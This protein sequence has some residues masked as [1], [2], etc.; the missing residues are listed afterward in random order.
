ML[1]AEAD[2]ANA[3]VQTAT[4][5]ANSLPDA[6]AKAQA[7]LNAK[8]LGESSAS[9][10]I[11]KLLDEVEANRGL[12]L[13][14][15]TEYLEPKLPKFLYF[16]EYYQMDGQVNIEQL[17]QRKANGQLKNSDRPMLGLIELA[18]LD[19]DKLLNPE[20][21][22]TLINKL[23][24]ASNHLSRQVLKYWS[25]NKHLQVKFD[26]RAAN[27]GDPDGMTNGTNLWG[28]VH[29]SVHFV[30]TRLGTRSK[31]FVWFFSFLAW[32]SQQK[33]Q[34]ENLVLLLDEPGLF[35]HAKAQ[36]DLLRY[37]EEELKPHHQVIY[38]THSPFMVDSK[39]FDRVRIV[40]DRSMDAVDELDDAEKGTKVLT[41]VLEASVDS[42]FPIQGALGYDIAQTL[43][44]GPNSLI[45]EGVSDLLYL[46][47]MSAVLESQN[48]VG[49]NSQWTITPVGGADKVPAF[50]SLIG[51]QAGMTVAALIDYQKK[52]AQKIENLY[53]RKLLKKS[54]VLTYADFTGGAEADVE[55]M[56]DISFYLRLVNGEFKANLEKNVTKA[57]LGKDAARVVVK[58]ETLLSDGRLKNA[59]FNH[60]RPARYFSE[61]L[62]NLASK[63][64]EE[65]LARFEAAFVAL[66]A[67][68]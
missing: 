26:V 52:D 36:A 15:W 56:F 33:K 32:F 51:S 65:S 39:H 5:E 2:L 9:V 29:D 8:A 57:S 10:A 47:T 20:R 12:N 24:G 13:H 63:I 27:A 4:T 64:P 44:V 66:N 1:S 11:R 53:K 58:I 67:I 3:A 7:L 35:L 61:N 17:K 40:E 45:V 50:C 59:K 42:L 31:G 6:T 48:R 38:S 41:E 62:S 46:Q 54:N 25:Q 28:R 30:S 14:I 22:E 21:T 49:L 19:L 55:D 68:I 34:D 43:F 60:Y 37:I 16:D 18:R 23:E